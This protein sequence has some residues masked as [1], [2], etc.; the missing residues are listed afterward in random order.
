MSE[1]GSIFTAG[2][3]VVFESLGETITKENLGWP[4]VAIRAA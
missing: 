1:Q 4:T 3:P 2:P